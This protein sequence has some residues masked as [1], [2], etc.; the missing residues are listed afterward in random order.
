MQQICV[1]CK[2]NFQ[3]EVEKANNCWCAQLPAI[4]PIGEEA[5]CLCPTCLKNKTKEAIEQYVEE[6]K[7]GIRKNDAPKKAEVKQKMIEDIDYYI[8]DGL[9]VMS[10]WF[11]LKRGYCCGSGCRHCPY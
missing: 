3:C 11:H 4:L 6:V 10:S 2:T 1:T 7:T 8:E 5:S 9:L